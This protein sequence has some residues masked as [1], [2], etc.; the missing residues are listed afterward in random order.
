MADAFGCSNGFEDL[1]VELVRVSHENPFEMFWDW[2]KETWLDL[3]DKPYDHN[4]PTH[5]AA[6][7]DVLNRRALPTPMEVLSFE[8]RI[9]GLSRV[10]LA[11]ITRGRIGHCYNVQS[12]MPQHIDHKVTIPKNVYENPMFLSRALKLQQMA[13]SLYD[14]MYAAGI[15]PQDCRYVT[16]HGQQTSMMWHVNFGALVGWYSMRCENGLTDELNFVGRKLRKLLFDRFILKQDEKHVNDPKNPNGYYSTLSLT[17]VTPGSGWDYLLPKLDCMGADR[18]VCLNTDK[19]FGNTG[20]FPS[21]SHSIP[22]SVNEKNKCD[23]KFDQSA[24]YYELLAADESLLFPGE[25]QM[26]E[27]WTTWQSCDIDGVSGYDGW[28]LILENKE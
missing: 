13:S 26:I 25:K 8:V 9:T 19:V 4:D 5:V 12:Q 14:D 21:V 28:L 27:H 2:Y 11:Q 23:F 18:G 16:L 7:V 3:H 1:N 6:C 22:S 17:P 10:A 24:M 15:P 20:R